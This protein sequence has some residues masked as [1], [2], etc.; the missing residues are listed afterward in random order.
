VVTGRRL[1]PGPDPDAEDGWELSVAPTRAEVDALEFVLLMADDENYPLSAA[2]TLASVL[3]AQELLWI[4]GAS[5]V[6]V[7]TSVPP[8]VDVDVPA[9][10]RRNVDPAPREWCGAALVDDRSDRPVRPL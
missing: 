6:A 8:G 10:R 2:R 7:N 5:V 9:T 4:E 3:L 1:L